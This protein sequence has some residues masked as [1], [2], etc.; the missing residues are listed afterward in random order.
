[1][2]RSNSIRARSRRCSPSS[3]QAALCAR[4]QGS[5]EEPHT[6]PTTASATTYRA[7]RSVRL[8]GIVWQQ[9]TCHHC[10]TKFELAG[11]ALVFDGE[12][13]NCRSCGRTLS[14]YDVFSMVYWLGLM[15]VYWPAPEYPWP[16]P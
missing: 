14:G 15:E 8:G 12:T 5:K 13:I 1:M 9:V 10:W 2:S 3:I 4:A 6:H 11:S 7:T 16:A